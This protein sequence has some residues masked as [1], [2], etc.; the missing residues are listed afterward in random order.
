[1]PEYYNGQISKLNQKSQ[2]PASIFPISLKDFTTEKPLGERVKG[3]ALNKYITGAKVG[4]KQNILNQSNQSISHNNSRSNLRYQQF[5][6]EN[7]L[8]DSPEKPLYFQSEKKQINE[9]YYD[10]YVVKSQSQTELKGVN[11][12]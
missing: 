5:H 4:G 3:D 6:N 9:A 10:E 2:E 1:M 12:F 7:D 11:K 8:Q